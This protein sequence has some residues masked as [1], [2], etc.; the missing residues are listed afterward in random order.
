VLRKYIYDP[1]LAPGHI[2]Y[3][4]HNVRP[5]RVQYM[6][7]R[8]M[9]AARLTVFDVRVEVTPSDDGTRVITFTAI[10][11]PGR[12]KLLYAAVV[13]QEVDREEAQRRKKMI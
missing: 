12:E 4:L 9:R 8:F 2:D 1:T 3:Q 6:T 11:D 10:S 7:D 13:A 5:E